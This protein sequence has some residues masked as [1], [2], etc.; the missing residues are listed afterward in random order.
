MFLLQFGCDRNPWLHDHHDTALM[1][2]SLMRYTAWSLLFASRETFTN[3]ISQLHDSRIGDAKFKKNMYFKTNMLVFFCAFS[4]I[5]KM[6]F[7]STSP[8]LAITKLFKLIY[9]GCYV[10]LVTTTL[11]VFF[12]E[13]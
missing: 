8:M 9:W 4:M 11:F 10:I 3:L 6:C 12:T 13:L 7:S 2:V 1:T 5:L